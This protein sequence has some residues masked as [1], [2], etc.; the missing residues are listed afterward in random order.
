M[1]LAYSVNGIPIRLTDERWNHIVNARDD[2]AGYDDDCLPVIE[3][4]DLVLAGYRGSLKAVKGY[5]RSRYLQVVY[6]E[7]WDGDGFVITAC[8]VSKIDRRAAVWP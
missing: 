7:L 8:F 3:E 5:G 1:D 6:K 2:M 4:P